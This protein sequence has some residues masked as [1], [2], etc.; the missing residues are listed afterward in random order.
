MG[1]GKVAQRTFV[2]EFKDG[3]L[4]SECVA[5]LEPLMHVLANNPIFVFL[6]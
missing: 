4:D 3:T 1:K 6:D 5:G 2:G